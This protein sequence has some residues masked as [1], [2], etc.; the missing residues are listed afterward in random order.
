MVRENNGELCL[1]FAFSEESKKEYK[2]VKLNYLSYS[3]ETARHVGPCLSESECFLISW[4]V[5]EKQNTYLFQNVKLNKIK[6][7][8]EGF[9]KRK[10]NIIIFDEQTCPWRKDKKLEINWLGPT[11]SHMSNSSLLVSSK[12]LSVKLKTE[13][14]IL[15]CGY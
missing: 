1:G 3:Y 13:Q 12:S 10:E 2:T 4:T 6:I 15:T 9:K 11:E 7:F 8:K 14:N 5:P